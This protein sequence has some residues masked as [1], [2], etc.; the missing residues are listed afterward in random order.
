MLT[1]RL[2]QRVDLDVLKALMDEAIF[3]N[4]NAYLLDITMHLEFIY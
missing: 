1:Y 2:A 4:Q 3:E